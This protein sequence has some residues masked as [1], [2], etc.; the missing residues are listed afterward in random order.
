MPWLTVVEFFLPIRIVDAKTLDIYV[1]ILS[2]RNAVSV[3]CTPRGE[4]TKGVRKSRGGT[5]KRPINGC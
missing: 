5:S 1:E 4:Y 3:G 2:N